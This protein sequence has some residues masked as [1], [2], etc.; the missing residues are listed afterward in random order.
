MEDKITKVLK[1]KVDPVLAAHYG[2]ALSL[3]HI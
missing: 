1:D 3:I 2:G